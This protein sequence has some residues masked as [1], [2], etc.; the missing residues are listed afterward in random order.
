[1]FLYY[2]EDDPWYDGA[3]VVYYF[4]PSKRGA[5]MSVWIVHMGGVQ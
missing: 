5:S 1:M 2:R 4:P 3:G